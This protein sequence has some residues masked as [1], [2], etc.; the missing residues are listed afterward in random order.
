[1]A[2]TLTNGDLR[3][4]GNPIAL[5]RD[6]GGTPVALM[7]GVDANDAIVLVSM[8]NGA[9]AAA[10][11]AVYAELISGVTMSG[12]A[13]MIMD[14]DADRRG[15]MLKNTGSV[16]VYLGPSNILSTADGIPVAAGATITL[17]PQGACYAGQI[18]GMTAGAAGEIRGL[19]Y[20]YSVVV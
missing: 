16:T 19:R 10:P 15:H 5:P 13:A 1:M 8:D 4:D 14:F 20:A 3:R 7:A 18:W 9:M 12:A 2:I 11:K 17:D 6:N